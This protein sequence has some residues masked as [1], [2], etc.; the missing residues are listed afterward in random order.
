MRDGRMITYEQTKKGLSAHY[1]KRWVLEDGL[2]T[3]PLEYH[4]G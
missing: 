4:K 2:H 3:K 1:D